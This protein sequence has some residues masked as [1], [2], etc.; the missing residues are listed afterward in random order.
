MPTFEMNDKLN[1]YEAPGIEAEAINGTGV[2][3]TLKIITK[4]VLANLKSGIN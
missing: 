3:E 4:K 2:T 1:R